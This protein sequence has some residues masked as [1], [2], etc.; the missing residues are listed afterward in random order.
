[1]RLQNCLGKT[2]CE[3]EL[4]LA[5]R[6]AAPHQKYDQSLGPRFFKLLP[7]FYRTGLNLRGSGF[8]PEQHVNYKIF[9]PSADDMLLHNL[10]L[11][12]TTNLATK[13]PPRLKTGHRK[14]V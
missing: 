14:L 2:G 11:D 13:L 8:E 1:L 5:D 9:I 7:N 10:I 12:A 6:E 3:N 4:N